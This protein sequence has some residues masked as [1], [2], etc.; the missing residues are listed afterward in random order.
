MSNTKKLIAV[1]GATGH[2]GGAVV[3][4]LQANGQFKV[5]ALT[6]NPSEHPQLA[7]EVV[8][9]DLDR[10]QTLEAAFAGA[11]GVFLVTNFWGPGTDERK[12]ALA[13]I[14]AAKAAGVQ[15]FIWSTLPNVE[16]ISRGKLDVP[17]FTDKAKIDGIVSEAG[18]AHHTY[19][20][21]PFF[22]Q[23]LLGMMAPKKQ[24][25]GTLGWAMPLDPQ[26]RVIHMGDITELGH[27]VV[28]A[29]A[30]PE[31]AG[32]GEYLPLVGDFL[33]FN[34]V[35]TDLNRLGH[36]FS[37]KHV[38]RE[39]FADW[40][41]GAKEIAEMLAYFEAHTYLGADS[42]DAIALA[43]KVAGR[44]PTKFAAWARANFEIPA[45]A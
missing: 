14:H 18:F 43:N 13:A 15:H 1:V 40:F 28:G 39:L 11:Y 12:Q 21:A 4:A 10:P 44:Q 30:Q 19:V 26:Q 16:T 22:Y 38:P 31:L 27:V 17:H 2:Q 3:R 25:D 34:E 41:P 23:N 45:S 37:F 6:R 24:A 9:A 36:D 35:I 32:N 42:R 33:S 5:R 7:D 8:L 20:I 29:F